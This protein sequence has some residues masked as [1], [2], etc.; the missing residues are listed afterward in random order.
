MAQKAGGGQG[1]QPQNNQQQNNQQQQAQPQN[2]N[3]QQQNKPKT[4][5]KTIDIDT[6]K[7]KYKTLDDFHE[8]LSKAGFF[9]PALK[10]KIMS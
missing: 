6:I 2:N 4:N 10:S 3:A 5:A 9:L 8:A 1:S 7:N